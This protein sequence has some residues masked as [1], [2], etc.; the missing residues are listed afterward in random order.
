MY[1]HAMAAVATGELLVFGQCA[2]TRK[3]KR[4]RGQDKQP[5][6]M[7]VFSLSLAHED[8][9]WRQCES[10]TAPVSRRNFS[11]ATVIDQPF[12][13]VLAGGSFNGNALLDVW[14]FD[15]LTSAWTQI[16]GDGFCSVPGHLSLWGMAGT[17]FGAI[18]AAGFSFKGMAQ[19]S[20]RLLAFPSS[21]DESFVLVATEWGD[22]WATAS[23]AKVAQEAPAA[24]T[25]TVIVGA[26][27][28]LF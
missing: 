23:R 5:D 28:E 21:S 6:Q 4:E 11:L 14:R 1:G 26:I 22:V 7:H 12:Q 24:E 2:R 3:Q 20:A 15:L 16:Q 10:P 9:Q 25:P 19:Q 13:V 8:R 17:P 18:L 27:E